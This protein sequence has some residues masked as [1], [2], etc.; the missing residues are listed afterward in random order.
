M[1]R[2][3]KQRRDEREKA[4]KK[5]LVTANV[6]CVCV[7]E[8]NYRLEGKLMEKSGASQPLCAWPK[9]GMNMSEKK[10][11]R[12]AAHRGAK[13][14]RVLRSASSVN[15]HCWVK[16]GNKKKAPVQATRKE[17]GLR[18]KS[19]DPGAARNAM[20]QDHRDWKCPQVAEWRLGHWRASVPWSIPAEPLKILVFPSG[21]AN[22]PHK[23][24]IGHN[25]T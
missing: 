7:G 4:R 8:R 21:G 17:A 3:L 18:R 23:H 9:R 14:R 15:D 12:R 11:F 19:E 6:V 20:Q 16:D 13:E 1:T 24:G 22:K 10:D 25:S 5:G 2:L